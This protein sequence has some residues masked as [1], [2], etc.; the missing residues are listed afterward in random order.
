MGTHQYFAKFDVGLAV[1]HICFEAMS[2]GLSTCILGWINQER[3]KQTLKFGDNERAAL[4]IAVGYANYDKLRT[5]QRRPLE[6]IYEYIG[7]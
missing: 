7:K 2:Q 5:K 4:V 6:A 3:I 1:A